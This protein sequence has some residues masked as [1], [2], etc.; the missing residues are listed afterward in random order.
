MKRSDSFSVASGAIIFLIACVGPKDVT[1]ASTA[2]LLAIKQVRSLLAEAAF[3]AELCARNKATGQ[4]TRSLLVQ[5][6][7]ELESAKKSLKD[8]DK[9]SPLIEQAQEAMRSGDSSQLR[10]I[11]NEFL[12]LERAE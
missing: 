6:K 5:A 3:S 10:A 2:E 4:F 8:D 7:E 11:A 1:F 9:A 12:A